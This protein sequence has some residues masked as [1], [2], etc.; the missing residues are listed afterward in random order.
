MCALHSRGMT[1]REKLE[2]P[3]WLEFRREVLENCGYQCGRCRRPERE[4][5]LHVHHPFYV[6]GREPWN[7]DVWDVECLCEDCHRKTHRIPDPRDDE[8][9]F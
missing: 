2:N 9:P 4:V 1:Y 6:S 3:R 8:V 7:Y 5:I